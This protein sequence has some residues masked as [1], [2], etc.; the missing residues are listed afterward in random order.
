MA[1]FLNYAS[2]FVYNS[3]RLCTVLFFYTANNMAV[4]IRVLFCQLAVL[5]SLTIEVVIRLRR[6]CIDISRR[7]EVSVLFYNS[8]I[9]NY[10][11]N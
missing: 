1:N 6:R 8:A 9:I 10:V 5:C 2:F 3:K 4:M 7:I 11:N